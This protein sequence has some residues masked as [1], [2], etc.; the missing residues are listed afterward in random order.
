VIFAEDAMDGLPERAKRYYYCPKVNKKEREAGLEGF[1]HRTPS[2][3]RG[4]KEGASGLSS[5]AAG[6]CRTYGAKNHHPTIKPIALMRY[7]CRLACPEDGIILDPF[8]GS[9]S[10]GIGAALEGFS[11]IGMEQD[12][13]YKAIADARIAHWQ[14]SQQS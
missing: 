14:E 11:F 9:G 10:T 7:L 2:E 12:P 3:I 1:P 8:M 6:A 13:E 5:A 4:C